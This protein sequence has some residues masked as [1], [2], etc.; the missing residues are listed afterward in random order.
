MSESFKNLFTEISTNAQM[1]TDLCTEIAASV[2]PSLVVKDLSTEIEAVYPTR[3]RYLFVRYDHVPERNEQNVPISRAIKLRLYNPDPAF[4]IDI[5]TFKM[6]LNSSAWYA[7]GNSRLTFTKVN[8]RE[9][10]I[11]FN[12][13][14]YNYD[15]KIDVEVYCEDHL[16]NKG[17]ELEIL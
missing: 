16:N 11:Y 10:L 5:T 3:S 12:P 6:R 2:I 4:G 8:Y 9:C 17:I 14:K 1:L 7:Y 13:E 15:S